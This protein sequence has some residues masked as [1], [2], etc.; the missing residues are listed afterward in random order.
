M[1]LNVLKRNKQIIIVIALP[2][3]L[4]L[5]NQ[6][7][8]EY[9]KNGKYAALRFTDVLIEQN[10]LPLNFWKLIHCKIC[11]RP[12]LSD[13]CGMG[14]V[15]G[16]DKFSDSENASSENTHKNTHHRVSC[17]LEL[18][19]H[20]ESFECIPI[21]TLIPHQKRSYQLSNCKKGRRITI[22]PSDILLLGS[23]KRF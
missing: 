23:D 10:L 4:Q 16:K 8:G 5:I 22:S 19:L 18:C 2:S 3:Q 17:K 21:W 9:W 12:F 6:S 13:N 1:I 7:M 15:F 11:E 14:L 20:Y